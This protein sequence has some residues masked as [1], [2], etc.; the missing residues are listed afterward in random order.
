MC[1]NNCCN[2]C[3]SG[4]RIIASELQELSAT[5]SGIAEALPDMAVTE[6]NTGIQLLNNSIQGLA[7]CT[8]TNLSNM[9]ADIAALSATVDNIFTYLILTLG[10]QVAAINPVNVDG[11]IVYQ[12]PLIDLSVAVGRSIYV[13]F[14][15]A[16]DSPYPVYIQDKAGKLYPLYQ[17][18]GTTPVTGNFIASGGNSF[19]VIVGTDSLTMD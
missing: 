8:C 6:D 18:D 2:F 4:T 16:I 3:D 13:V 12:L 1:G 17:S 5:M 14:N 10:G 19:S 9:A 11:R 7:D 15:A